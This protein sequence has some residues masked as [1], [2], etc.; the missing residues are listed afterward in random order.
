MCAVYNGL[1]SAQ[2]ID[3]TNRCIRA[4]Q[5]EENNM[6]VG[7][8]YTLYINII[9]YPSWGLS[10]TKVYLGRICVILYTYT[11][12]RV[13]RN[14]I[15]SRFVILLYV[16]TYICRVHKNVYLY[17]YRDRKCRIFI[18]ISIIRFILIT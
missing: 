2:Y 5:A 9:L 15:F 4:P 14:N 12:N 3:V 1:E 10:I 11:Y 7:S 8:Y 16:G 13:I 18:K 6:S 17:T